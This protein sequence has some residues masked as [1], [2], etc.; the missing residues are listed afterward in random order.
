MSVEIAQ[1][2]PRWK[3]LSRLL[4]SSCG[5]DSCCCV[6]FS[7]GGLKNTIR[8]PGTKL[9]AVLLCFSL[10]PKDCK[11]LRKHRCLTAALGRRQRGFI[12]CGKR[13]TESQDDTKT[14]DLQ[15]WYCGMFDSILKAQCMKWRKL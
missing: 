6:C 8:P 9:L 11:A 3:W 2:E 13:G 7:C 10:L 12:W 14:P 15:P 5:E 4:D 1:E